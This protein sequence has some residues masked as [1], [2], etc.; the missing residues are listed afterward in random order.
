MSRAASA[1]ASGRTRTARI[2][3]PPR[4]SPIVCNC[5]VAGQVART[6][7]VA[8]S[9]VLRPRPRLESPPLRANPPA[10]STISRTTSPFRGSEAEPEASAALKIACR[11]CQATRD[12][13]KGGYGGKPWHGVPL[14]R[15]VARPEPEASATPFE[16]RPLPERRARHRLACGR[17]AVAAERLQED[18]AQSRDASQQDQEGADVRQ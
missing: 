5:S 1:H 11:S 9:P 7:W 15:R 14:L 13:R 17:S 6:R 18:S 3:I 2:A 16:H 4:S 8:S 12:D 10:R